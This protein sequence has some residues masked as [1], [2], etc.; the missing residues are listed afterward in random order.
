MG[1]KSFKDLDKLS[2]EQI[3]QL[4]F[5]YRLTRIKPDPTIHDT[6]EC[7][8]IVFR[9]NRFLGQGMYE[10]MDEQSESGYIVRYK[11]ID[12]APSPLEPTKITWS[13]SNSKQH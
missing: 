7:W 6:V 1:V 2:I 9:C 8:E 10:L 4:P 3:I 5:F 13:R 12:F 11:L